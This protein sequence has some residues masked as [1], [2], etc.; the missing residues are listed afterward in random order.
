MK[1]QASPKISTLPGAGREPE[2]LALARS[3]DREAFATLYNATRP[4]VMRFIAS[5]VRDKHQAEDLTQETYIRALRGVERF[6][7]QGRDFTAWLTVIARNLI[8]DHYRDSGRRPETLVDD[9]Q[10]FDAVEPSAESAILADLDRAVVRRALVTLNPDHRRVI[11]LQVW[12][13]LSCG[14]IAV[15]MHRSVGAVKTL[16][17][18]AI[19]NLR[20]ALVLELAA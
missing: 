11:V 6:T 2:L 1:P 19:A 5:R 7:W 15:E 9:A 17:H 8:T 14:Q 18:R 16:R 10:Y 3:G 20:R 12:S 4:E 13:G